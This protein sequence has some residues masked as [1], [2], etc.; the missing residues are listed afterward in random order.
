MINGEL[1]TW[2]SFLVILTLRRKYLYKALSKPGPFSDPDWVPGN[3]T[4]KSLEES[5]ILYVFVLW[6]YFELMLICFQGDVSKYRL[7]AFYM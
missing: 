2:A 4:I 6:V 1:P 5:K 7:I 3:E